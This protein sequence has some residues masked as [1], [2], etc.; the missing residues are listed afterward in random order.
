MKNDPAMPQMT[1]LVDKHIQTVTIPAFC[2]FRGLEERL[3]VLCRGMVDI[4]K[5][6]KSNFGR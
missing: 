2:L 5:R 1:D 4:K 6:L 3:D